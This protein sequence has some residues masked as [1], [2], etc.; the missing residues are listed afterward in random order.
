[1]TLWLLCFCYVYVAQFIDMLWYIVRAVFFEFILFSVLAV[2][3]DECHLIIGFWLQY[4]EKVFNL[5]GLDDRSYN[6]R[7]ANSKNTQESNNMTQ[8]VVRWGLSSSYNYGRGCCPNLAQT[9]THLLSLTPHCCE[10]RT[11]SFIMNEFICSYIF[12]HPTI[13]WCWLLPCSQFHLYAALHVTISI[14]LPNFMI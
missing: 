5:K 2:L 13:P 14:L 12:S 9:K 7:L 10:M 4:D 3:Q 8:L 11:S 6:A 1:M